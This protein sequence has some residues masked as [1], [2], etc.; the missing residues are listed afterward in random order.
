M[1][2]FPEGRKGTEKLYKDRYQLRRFGRGGFVESAMRAAPDRPGRRRR[3]RGGDAGLRA[4]RACAEPDRADLLPDH[5]PVRALRACSARRPACRRSSSPLPGAGPDGPWGGALGDGGARADVAD[6]VRARSRPSWSTSSRIAARCGSDELQARPRHRRVDLLGRPGRPGARARSAARRGR[7]RRV[8]PAIRGCE[9]DRTEFVRVATGHPLLRRLVRAAGSTPSSTPGWSSAAPG[10]AARRARGQRASGRCTSSPRAAGRTR[11]CA[12]SSSSPRA[13]YYGCE[14]DDPA[15]SPRTCSARTRRAT[16]LEADI[17]EAD[18]AVQVF[19][20]RNPTSR[21][22]RCASATGSVPDLETSHTRAAGRCPPSPGSSAST[23]ATSSSTRTT[24]SARCARGRSTRCRGSTT[25]RRDGVLALSEVASLLGKPLRAG[26]AAVGYVAGARAA[27]GLVGLR[28]PDEVRQQLRYGRGLDNRR[29]KAAGYRFA[30][31]SR[32]TVQ[33]L[34]RGAA[35]RAAARERGRAISLRARGRGVPALCRRARVAR[36]RLTRQ[37]TCSSSA[38][39]SPPLPLGRPY[40]ETP[41]RSHPPSWRSSALASG[42]W[43]LRVRPRQARA[44]RGGRGGQRRG[45]SA[46]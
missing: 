23:R 42:G 36:R 21:S 40:A 33:A 9:L 2:V 18:D 43:R 35:A 45:R 15:S 4:A 12:R 29:L 6:D 5:A 25:W 7:R 8:A 10:A 31:T 26:A 28:V 30:L 20:A 22:P 27:L 41:D 46:A 3:R 38:S 34:R 37:R 44:D 1:L 17:V 13:H 19:A 39:H 11:R 24:S 16:P 14:R 32:E